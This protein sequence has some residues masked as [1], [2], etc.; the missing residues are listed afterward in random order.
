M[1]ER[2]ERQAA[3]PGP[4]NQRLVERLGTGGAKVLARLREAQ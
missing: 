3:H 2:G 1:T 4:Q